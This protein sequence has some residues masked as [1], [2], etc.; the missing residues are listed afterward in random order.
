MILLLALLTFLPLPLALVFLVS[1]RPYQAGR[2]D[3]LNAISCAS[4]PLMVVLVY[5]GLSM[6][7]A[8]NTHA[9]SQALW[10]KAILFP[11]VLGLAYTASVMAGCFSLSRVMKGRRSVMLLAALV[12][13]LVMVG[14]SFFLS[15]DLERGAL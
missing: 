15:I 13:S 11:F 8:L 9:V 10:L 4:A 12:S 14:L 6:V 1:L 2:S 5:A 3:L 7:E